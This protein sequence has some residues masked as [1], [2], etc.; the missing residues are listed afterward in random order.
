L[1]YSFWPHYGPVSTERV[2]E[3]STK[4]ISWGIKV[5]GALG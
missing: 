5:S 1:K 2:T 4:N 3:M